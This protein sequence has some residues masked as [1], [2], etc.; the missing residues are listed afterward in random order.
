M[1]GVFP[2]IVA[3]ILPI[4]PDW[5]VKPTAKR[6]L[7]M[8]SGT[9]TELKCRYCFP[10]KLLVHQI[11]RGTYLLLNENKDRELLNS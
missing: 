2:S 5:N 11:K 4:K 3:V 1:F 6:G 10:K 8:E 9:D 7:V